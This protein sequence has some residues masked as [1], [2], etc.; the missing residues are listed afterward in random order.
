MN[1]D[2]DFLNHLSIVNRECERFWLKSLS[3]DRFK[4]L[5][6]TCSLQSQKFSDIRSRLLCRLDQD[7]KLILSGMAN[8][9]QSLIN[10]QRDLTMIQSDN[11]SRSE[12]RVVQQIPNQNKCAPATPSPSHF[13]SV[14]EN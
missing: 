1:E 4:A 11:S 6:L 10:L 8:E 9:Y 14:P 3:K 13:N 7:P 5:I 2:D 12:V